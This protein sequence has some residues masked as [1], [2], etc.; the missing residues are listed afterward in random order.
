MPSGT[1]LQVSLLFKKHMS[2]T[3]QRARVYDYVYHLLPG[4]EKKIELQCSSCHLYSQES[5]GASCKSWATDL[6]SLSSG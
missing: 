4:G 2:I 3:R 1:H 5:T 6:G